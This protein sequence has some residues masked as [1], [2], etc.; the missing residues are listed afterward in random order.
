MQATFT[1]KINY[2]LISLEVLSIDHSQINNNILINKIEL[3]NVYRIDT[4]YLLNTQIVYYPYIITLKLIAMLYR[5]IKKKKLSELIQIILKR[6]ELLHQYINKFYRLYSNNN[7]Y[8]SYN[9]AKQLKL[10]YIAIINLYIIYT[11]DR[12]SHIGYIIY[13]LLG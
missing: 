10:K 7:S 3:N 8:T 11:I 6:K 12:E 5:S 1:K 4:L 9:Y 2:L 13:Y